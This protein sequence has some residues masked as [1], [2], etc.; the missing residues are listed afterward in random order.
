MI[1]KSEDLLNI[2]NIR[3]TKARKKILDYLIKTQNCVCI[4]KIFDDIKKSIDIDLATVYR[5]VNLFV[6][7]GI[8]RELKKH[9]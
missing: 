1:C 3:I 5:S 2:N 9:F 7:K 4:Q 8:I 6:E